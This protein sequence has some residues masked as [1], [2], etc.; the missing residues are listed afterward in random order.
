MVFILCVCII[1]IITA[2]SVS[3][4]NVK[5]YIR[6]FVLVFIPLT[7]IW[8]QIYIANKI[9]VIQYSTRMEQFLSLG[10]TT[11]ILLAIESAVLYIIHT[12]RYARIQKISSEYSNILSIIDNLFRAIMITSYIIGVIILID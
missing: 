7:I 10:F 6:T 11:T 5:K 2:C 1:L 8:L 3:L 4:I 9:P 12:S